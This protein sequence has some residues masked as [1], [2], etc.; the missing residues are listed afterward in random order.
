MCD[1]VC[2]VKYCANYCANW[3]RR[4]CLCPHHYELVRYNRYRVVP[5]HCLDMLYDWIDN[6]YPNEVP[7]YL[8]LKEPAELLQENKV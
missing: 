1:S 4:Y 7:L 5:H 8:L 3:S 6:L 2:S